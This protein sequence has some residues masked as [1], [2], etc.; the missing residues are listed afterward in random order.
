[1]FQR[2]RHFRR[3]VIHCMNGEIAFSEIQ[4][5]AAL[6]YAPFPSLPAMIDLQDVLANISVP[7]TARCLEIIVNKLNPRV[8]LIDCHKAQAI[9]TVQFIDGTVSVIIFWNNRRQP[10]SVGNRVFVHS[11]PSVISYLF[12]Q[13]SPGIFYYIVFPHFMS[14]QSAGFAIQ[15]E[16]K[17]D[18]ITS[19]TTV[20]TEKKPMLSK[21]KSTGLML[22]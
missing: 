7:I 18:Y 14:L 11:I 2:E 17:L 4:A 12:C 19:L 6:Q 1:M 21:W 20:Q 8:D 16:V 15:S 13:D 9:R 5:G 10:R 3:T 22:G